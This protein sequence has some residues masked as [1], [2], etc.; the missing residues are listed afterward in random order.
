MWT[1]GESP[2]K[3]CAAEVK[4]YGEWITGTGGHGTA[5]SALSLRLDANFTHYLDIKKLDRLSLYRAV[6]HLDA[7][8]AGGQL[9]DHNDRPWVRLGF[10]GGTVLSRRLAWPSSS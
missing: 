10:D 6:G 9:K 3:Q 8:R 1:D 2:A 4:R 5:Q 7:A